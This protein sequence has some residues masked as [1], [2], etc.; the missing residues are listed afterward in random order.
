M[1]YVVETPLPKIPVGL[2]GCQA[3]N[4]G[5]AL[6]GSWVHTDHGP[7]HWMGFQQQGG[8]LTSARHWIGLGS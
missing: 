2:G 6:Q 1:R 5:R 4:Q 7:G 8:C 3:R